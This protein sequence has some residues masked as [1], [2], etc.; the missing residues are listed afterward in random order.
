MN[1]E[2]RSKSLQLEAIWKEQQ[3]KTYFPTA[4]VKKGKEKKSAQ[5]KN[6]KCKTESDCITNNGHISETKACIPSPTIL[7]LKG[8]SSSKAE[9]ASV[10][11]RDVHSSNISHPF[12]KNSESK[13]AVTSSVL[14]SRFL[15]YIVETWRCKR[16]SQSSVQNTG[17]TAQISAAPFG[18]SALKS[19][20][21]WSACTWLPTCTGND[22]EDSGRRD[23]H[24]V[25]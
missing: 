20:W 21:R 19:I 15:K 11:R 14:V 9:L 6:V 16:Q 23:R 3:T 1:I 10:A 7:D 5:Y 17:G 8:G 22:G 2:K 24:L 18:L 13:S 25:N 4:E 12:R